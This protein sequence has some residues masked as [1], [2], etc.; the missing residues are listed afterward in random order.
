MKKLFVMLLSALLL[1]GAV[2]VAPAFATENVDGDSLRWEQETAVAD[3]QADMVLTPT[4][5]RSSFRAAA[6]VTVRA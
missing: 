1:C 3:S 5:A 4:R 6:T 2:S